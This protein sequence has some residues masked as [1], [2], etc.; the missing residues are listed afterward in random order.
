MKLY[1]KVDKL[2][3]YVAEFLTYSESVRGFSSNSVAGYKNDLAYLM[4][5]LGAGIAPSEITADDIRACVGR[6]S[7][8]NSAASSVNRF[9]AAVRAF[10][11]YLRRFGYIPTN[12]AREIKT[13]KQPQKLPRF[14]TEGEAEAL[15]T[16]PRK[17]DILWP[18]R[19]AALFEMFYSSGC[20]VGELAGIKMTDFTGGSYETAIILGKGSKERQVFFSADA[21][22][23]IREYLPER[24][25]WLRECRKKTAAVFVNRR[26]TALTGRGMQYILERYSG[27]E[28]TNKHVS[29]HAFR[30][31]FATALLN[32]GADVRIVQEMLGH[33]NISTTQR[34]THISGDRL[35]D[36]YRRS[37]PHG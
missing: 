19:D 37:H 18:A 8:Q 14:M 24:E 11:A 26:G 20:R 25:A 36:V 30:H 1:T 16:L 12:P 28:G 6:L 3:D 17:K 34:Y 29:P 32:N 31:S 13:V 21:L 15:C 22:R 27:V 9:I 5:V 7:L 4:D 23:A 10:F 2:D 35:I 33:A